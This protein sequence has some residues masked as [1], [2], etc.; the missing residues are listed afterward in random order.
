MVVGAGVRTLLLVL[1][2]V[3]TP[4]LA[5]LVEAVRILADGVV[6]VRAD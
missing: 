5:P 6:S 4:V 3:F 2:D 1:V